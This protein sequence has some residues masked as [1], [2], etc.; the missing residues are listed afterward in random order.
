MYGLVKD[1]FLALGAEGSAGAGLFFCLNDAT[2]SLGIIDA[3]V[4]RIL[5]ATVLQ[6]RSDKIVGFHDATRLATGHNSAISY[7][8]QLSCRFQ[9]PLVITP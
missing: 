6:L 8:L 9:A 7:L 1:C 5:P 3:V 2:H 4:F